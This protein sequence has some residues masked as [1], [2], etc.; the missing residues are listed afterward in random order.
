MTERVKLLLFAVGIGILL[1]NWVVISL[2]RTYYVPWSGLI[3][4]LGWGMSWLYAILALLHKFSEKAPRAKMIRATL[5]AATV[6]IYPVAFLI[7]G[8]MGEGAS[9]ELGSH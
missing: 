6:F 3:T 5:V 7:L 9:N 2:T 1:L 8:F 4:I